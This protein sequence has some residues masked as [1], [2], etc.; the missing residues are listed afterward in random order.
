MKERGG[1]G[2]L[3]RV[4]EKNLVFLKKSVDKAVVRC[5]NKQAVRKRGQRVVLEN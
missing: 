2:A 4:C 1:K 3:R 5:Y